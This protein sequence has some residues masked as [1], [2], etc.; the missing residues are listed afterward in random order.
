MK[1]TPLEQALD[2]AA[3]GIPVF[4]WHVSA[5]GQKVPLT[6]RG[7]HKH[8]TTDP[9]QIAAWW[10]EHPGAFIGSPLPDHATLDIDAH[11]IDGTQTVKLLG[12]ELEGACR[13]LTRSGGLHAHFRAPGRTL[14][15]LA[16]RA[17]P[18]PGLDLLGEGGWCALPSP[19]SGYTYA[20]GVD[21]QTAALLPDE[22]RAIW[23]EMTDDEKAMRLAAGVVMKAAEGGRRDELNSACFSH[24]KKVTTGSVAADRFRVWMV[25]A[26]RVAG[27]PD[28]E[29]G[30]TIEDA[31][32]DARKQVPPAQRAETDDPFASDEYESGAGDWLPDIKPWPEPVDGQALFDDMCTCIHRYVRLDDHQAHA[33]ALWALFAH[34][35]DKFFVSPR[36]YITAATRRCGKT[37][38]LDVVGKLV[39]RPVLTSHLTTA[40]LFRSIDQFAPTVLVDEMDNLVRNREAFADMLGLLNAGH[41]RGKYV[42]RVEG[43]DFKVKA[44]E[45][46]APIAMDGIGSLPDTLTDRCIIV[47]LVRKARSQAV[48]EFTLDETVDLAGLARKAARWSADNSEM[49]C[50]LRPAT[51]KALHDRARDNWAPLLR[52]AMA[53]SPDV[54]ALAQA[55]ATALAMKD[56]EVDDDLPLTLLRDCMEIRKTTTGEHIATSSLIGALASMIDSPWA[57]WKGTGRPVS[58]A[59][60]KNLLRPFAV[61]PCLYG[62]GNSRFRGYRWALIEAAFEPYTPS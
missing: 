19:E 62:T 20:N 58:G 56:E 57:D 61:A 15:R 47:R 32:K 39:P 26:G 24:G 46:F 4:P 1:V 10:A 33:V 51:P 6:G 27:L 18:Y 23:R 34:S 3:Q 40:A 55:A 21:L 7:G 44:F 16:G 48:A 49:A 22:V 2:Y 41:E 52:I 38:L 50:K 13:V 28:K 59:M 17:S 25:T 53:I 54:L 12:L 29:I 35:I 43:K 30:K 14:K 5:A 9:A 60:V 36:L 31:L 42:L 11:G 8:A 45:V 37:R